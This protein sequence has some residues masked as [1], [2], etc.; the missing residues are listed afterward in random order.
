MT[1]TYLRVQRYGKWENV[2]IEYLTDSERMM[3]LKDQPNE[4]LILWLNCVSKTLRECE[5]FHEA[6]K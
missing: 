2:E 1:G 5:F 3:T 6:T 4:R